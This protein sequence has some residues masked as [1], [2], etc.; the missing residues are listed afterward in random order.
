MSDIALVMALKAQKEAKKAFGSTGNLFNPT[1]VTKNI[2]L[3]TGGN[4]V[5]T[6]SYST[7]D[8]IPVEANKQYLFNDVRAVVFYDANKNLASGTG[9]S[10]NPVKEWLL[11]RARAGTAFVRVSSPISSMESSLYTVLEVKNPTKWVGKVWSSFGDSITQ[12]I[13]W[14]PHVIEALGFVHYNHGIGGTKVA[15]TTG[16]DTNAMC[17]DERINQLPS[18]SNLITFMGGTNDW[19]NNVPLGTLS[20]TGTDT[21][22][23]AVKKVAEKLLTRF[24]DRRIVFMTTP[25]GKNP[26]K[27]GW[28][29]S[30]GLINNL[31]LTTS[32]Y[33]KVIMEVARIYGFPC[34]DIYGMAGIHDINITTFMTADGTYVHPN[35]EGAK[36]IAEIVIG[37]LRAIEPVN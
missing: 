8:Y 28:T 21:F 25:Y 6:E 32:D 18:N 3:D 13:K 35:D 29:D 27:A 12:Q 34:L 14:Q 16:T 7:S 23:G 20:D 15:D 5:P 30:Y 37:G 19:G 26:N 31:G 24:P 17:R 4:S 33:G 22:Y 1:T 36:R 2:V 11:V 10:Y 9:A